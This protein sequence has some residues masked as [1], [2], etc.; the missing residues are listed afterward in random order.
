MPQ[1]RQ[2]IKTTRRN[3]TVNLSVNQKQTLLD[4]LRKGDNI[5]FF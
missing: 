1:K 5:T 3:L 4:N 2:Q